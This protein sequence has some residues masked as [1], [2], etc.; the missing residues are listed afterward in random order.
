MPWIAPVVAAGAAIGSGVMASNAQAA[1]RQQSKEAYEQSVKDLEAI[2]IPSVEAQKIVIE[3]YKSQ[4]QWTPEM[5]QAVTL[6]DSQMGGITT[7][8]AYKESQLKALGKLSQIGDEGGMLLEDKANMERIQGDIGAR[9]RGAREAILQDA[10]QRGGHGSGSALVAQLMSQQS[11][12]DQAHR[13]GLE[14]AAMAQKR[15][16]EAIQGAGSLGTNLRTQE[17][18]EKAQ[19]AKAQDAIAQWNAANRQDLNTRNAGTSNQAAQ[20]N[21]N[22][23]QNLANSNVD[24]RNKTNAYNSSLIQAQYN[25]Q[26]E[27]AKAKAAA[28]AGQ[29]QNAAQSGQQVAQTLT[30]VGSAVA[31]GAIATG[32]QVNENNNRE[33]DRRLY[34]QRYGLEEAA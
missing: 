33:E 32:Q 31:Q 17:Y 10:Q 7:D 28:R 29:A 2:G 5:E 23:R 8:P 15:A 16:L 1:A 26:L 14:T 25:N 21:L 34:R 11:G 9:Q 22:N 24:A 30:G 4:G 19:A 13:A 6:G 18:G 12:A 27:A 20:Y 3:E